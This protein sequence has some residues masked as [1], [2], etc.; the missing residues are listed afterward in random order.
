MNHKR[1]RNDI[2]DLSIAKINEFLEL[3]RS[4]LNHFI[5]YDSAQ[6][7]DNVSKNSKILLYQ[8][9]VYLFLYCY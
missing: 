2:G 6:L 1:K 9:I 4:D 8:L 5:R 3:E 7:Y